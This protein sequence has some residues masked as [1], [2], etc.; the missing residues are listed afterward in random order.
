M[1]GGDQGLKSKPK[2][3]IGVRSD[4]R[5]RAL[6]VG[7]D[8]CS[9]GNGSWGTFEAKRLDRNSGEWLFSTTGGAPKCPAPN[10]NKDRSFIPASVR[11]QIGQKFLSQ[12]RFW[13]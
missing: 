7:V 1:G 5:K 9:Q 8:F 2:G 6:F 4:M 13:L 11:R 10:L 12:L 3:Q